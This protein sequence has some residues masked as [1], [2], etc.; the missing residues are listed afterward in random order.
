MLVGLMTA[1]ALA[2]GPSVVASPKHLQ[3]GLDG[4]AA[5]GALA[6]V[7]D[8]GRVW[9]GSS[10][11][12]ELGSSRKVPVAGRFRIG[13][14]TKTFV[15]TVV[16]RLVAERRL[17][18]DDSVERWLPGVVPNGENITVRQLLNHTSGLYDFKDTLPMPPSPEFYA[19]RYRTWTAP[20]QIERALAHPPVFEEPGSRYDY[21]NT[22]YLLVGEIIQKVTGRTY[23]EEIER[24]LIRPLHLHGTTLPGTSPYIKGPHPHGYLPKDGGMVDYTE[25]N[26]TLF[27]AGGDMIST[28]RDLNRFFAALLGGRLLPAELLAEM[29][30]PGTANGRYGLGLSWHDTTCKVRVYGNDGD[31]L[32][33]Q[34]YSFATEDTRRQATVAVTPRLP[35]N[36]D[37]SVEAFLDRA[38]C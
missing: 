14:V 5:I 9:R 36:P 32:A 18:L 20:E 17:G 29:K 13:S 11:V 27:G 26:P 6:E 3:E 8:G 15:A 28:T 38:F 2:V 19:L 30:T 16:L 35:V 1:A 12:A 22:N 25:L 34:A 37:D 4:V 33:Y 21:S 23:A 24:R 10:G 7:R 31:A